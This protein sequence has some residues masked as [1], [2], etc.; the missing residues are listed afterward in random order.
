MIEQE[1]QPPHSIAV[2]KQCLVENVPFFCVCVCV[3]VLKRIDPRK[4]PESDEINKKIFKKKKKQNGKKKRSGHFR[5][6]SAS[7]FRRVIKELAIGTRRATPPPSLLMTYRSGSP[8]TEIKLIHFYKYTHTHTHI[9]IYSYK[10]DPPSCLNNVI[11]SFCFS[12]LATSITHT[13]THKKHYRTL[14]CTTPVVP[15]SF[16]VRFFFVRFCS[17]NTRSS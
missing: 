16:S 17:L 11:F 7:A 5:P 12:S 13:H 1:L 10:S 2:K 14:P 8:H 3:C 4:W 6:P 15:E 9:Y